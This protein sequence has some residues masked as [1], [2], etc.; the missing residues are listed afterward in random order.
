MKKKGRSFLARTTLGFWLIVIGGLLFLDRTTSVDA[1]SLITDWW[2]LII[3]YYGVVSLAR[4]SNTQGWLL[5]V[6]GL[7]LQ[8]H[9]LGIISRSHMSAFWP[10][11]II[12]LGLWLIL[13]RPQVKV[14]HK[15]KPSDVLNV[16]T[17]FG[18]YNEVLNSTAF[19]GG[20]ASVIFGDVDIDLRNVNFAVERPAIEVNVIF[21]DLEIILPRNCQVEFKPMAILGEAKEDLLANQEETTKPDATVYIHGSVL[22]GA[23]KVRN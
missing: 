7:F 4:R 16:T 14:D 12:L 2:P 19:R 3:I 18:S 1:W 23:L 22:F 13:N 6:I 9:Q 15:A 21:G 8:T 5:L 10:L 17:I 20:Q 11:V